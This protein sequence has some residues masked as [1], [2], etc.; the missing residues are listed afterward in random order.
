MAGSPL[1]SARREASDN[2]IVLGV[3]DAVERDPTITQRS[4]ALELG[5]ALGLANAYLKRCARKGLIKVSQAP[6][7][8]YAYYLT[9]KG[10]AEKSRLT[11]SYLSHSFGFFREARAQCAEALRQAASQAQYRLVLIGASE[12]SEIARLVAREHPVEIAGTLALGADLNALAGELRA[13]GSIDAALVTAIER[14][15]EAL[16]AALTLFGPECVYVPALLRIRHAGARL[17][18]SKPR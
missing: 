5:I 6:A 7:R 9:P 11:A 15:H 14:P 13:L 4:V 8:R 17:V 10:F 16:E 1:Q 3:L 12:L 2:D 18:K